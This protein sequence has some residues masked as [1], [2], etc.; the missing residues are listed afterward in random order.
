M[1][2]ALAAG[3]RKSAGTLVSAAPPRRVPTTGEDEGFLARLFD[4]ALAAE[5][6]PAFLAAVLTWLFLS[7]DFALSFA[8]D[9]AAGDLDV[10][11]FLFAFFLFGRFIDNLLGVD[12]MRAFSPRWRNW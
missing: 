3:A 6:L 9:F 4:A 1:R 7:A 2:A 5:G 10:L 12:I 11:V 8:A